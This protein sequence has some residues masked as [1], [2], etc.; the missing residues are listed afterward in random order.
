MERPLRDP[1]TSMSHHPAGHLC[2]EPLGRP[3]P[4]LKPSGAPHPTPRGHEASWLPL[5]QSKQG[6]PDSVPGCPIWRECRAAAFYDETCGKAP[7]T[8]PL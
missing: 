4:Q 7:A 3:L 8:R 6:S 5:S 1:L 2:R